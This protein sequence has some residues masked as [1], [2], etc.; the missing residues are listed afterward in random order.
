MTNPIPK[1]KERIK[2]HKFISAIV[3]IALVYGV[4]WGYQQA[5]PATV[6]IQYTT[7][8]A[9]KTTIS[10]AVSGSGQVLQKSRLDLK[11]PVTGSGN[12]TLTA[13]N[14]KNGDNVKAGQ[15]I[16]VLDQKNSAASLSQAKASMLSA[17]ANYDKLV[18]GATVYDIQLSQNSVNQAQQSYKN[19]QAQLDN[20]KLS[21]AQSLAQ[22]QKDLNDLR[23]LDT[24]AISN[25][26]RDNV[27]TSIANALNTD[28]TA[29][30]A[31]NKALLDNVLKDTFSAKDTSILTNLNDTYNKSLPMINTANASL[32][33][34][35][36][37]KS[38]TNLDQASSDAVNALNSTL[39]SLNYCYDAIRNTVATA[40]LSQSQIDAYKSSINGQIGSINS[41]IS[42]IQSS[43]QALKDAIT[44]A[45]N[46]LINTQISTNQQ[47]SSAQNSVQSSYNSWQS[48]ID[49][50]NKL[51]AP[52]TQQDLDIAKA[53]L[54]TADGNY[55]QALNNYNSNII[56][57]PFDGL[58]AAANNQA[59]DQVSGSSIIA[60]LITKQQIAYIPLN[61][62]DV[63][64]IAKGDNAVLTFDAIDAL[65]L[66][67][68]VTDIDTLG[69]VSQ[70]V[71]N[72]NVTIS[73]IDQ[74]P[75]VKPGMSVAADIITNVKT[76]VLAVP[77][78]AV[79][80]TAN[81]SYVQT[82]DSSGQ[83]QNVVVQTGIANDSY[84]EIISG[85]N[86]GDKVITQ[87]INPNAKTTTP[88]NSGGGG[89]G[90]L[91]IPGLTGGRG[92]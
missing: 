69:T 41:S 6:A 59:G 84:T 72:Y 55:Q 85:L 92:G 3:A 65:S 29:L 36:T 91:R 7:E 47:L 35:K 4:Y 2:K 19:A 82:L 53:Q 44:T 8:A 87:T 86:E 5:Y 81:G 68:K 25:N 40:Q 43:E 14:V 45:Q 50:F 31:E 15:V 78:A 28:T 60:T 10:V 30:D 71:V 63:A 38:D 57:A 75:R 11:P 16:A 37:Y 64:K 17:Q 49:S 76:D 54:I 24:S 42:S 83:P 48:A 62:V 79:K 1:L 58:I 77:N 56:T 73:M 46:N 74:D 18:A 13:V 89:G 80:S 32:A 70:G 66:T 90:G 52:A 33:T 22:A 27:I 23:T 34:A 61:E 21:I 9:A 67:G 51:K 26:K 20:A 12:L 88:T 39:S